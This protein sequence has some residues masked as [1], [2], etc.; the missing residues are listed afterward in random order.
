MLMQYMPGAHFFFSLVSGY[1]ANVMA[2]KAIEMH[3]NRE[4]LSILGWLRYEQAITMVYYV[5]R[6][7]C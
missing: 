1:E 5:T 4:L 7:F 2:T 3:R 6:R